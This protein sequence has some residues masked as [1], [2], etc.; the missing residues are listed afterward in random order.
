MNLLL[1]LLCA[2]PLAAALPSQDQALA[3][4]FPGAVLTP[5]PYQ[6]D[7]AQAARAK[8]LAGR[9]LP[10]RGL[11]V[12]A[13]REGRL[14]GVGFLDRHR[15]RTQME[16]ALVAVG[17]EGRLLRVEV[18]EFAEPAEYMARGAW[19]RQ[20]DGQPLG[21]GLALGRAIKPLAG[22]TLTAGALADAARRGLAL[23]QVLYGGGR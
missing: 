1:P 22:A 15:V 21:D 2:L 13:R 19:L 16:T 20:F 11:A 4:A 23:Y 12:E 17:A 18:V 5:R 9:D 3:L 6:L 8:A 14:A 10:S 7:P